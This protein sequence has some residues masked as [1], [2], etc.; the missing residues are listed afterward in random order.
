[1][2]TAGQQRLR[3]PVA[4]CPLVDSG[5]EAQIG[6][7]GGCELVPGLIGAQLAPY[8]DRG[9]HRA[10]HRF[11][12][13]G[14]TEISR[15]LPRFEHQHRDDPGEFGR[16]ESLPQPL[17]Q[18]FGDHQIRLGV[19]T[20]EPATVGGH[21]PVADISAFGQQCHDPIEGPRKRIGRGSDL[22][23]HRLVLPLEPAVPLAHP[24]QLFAIGPG[25]RRMRTQCAAQRRQLPIV[26]RPGAPT[27]PAA[28]GSRDSG[29]AQCRRQIAPGPRGAMIDVTRQSHPAQWL[30]RRRKV[31]G[32]YTSGP[33]VCG[34][35]Q[36]ARIPRTRIRFQDHG[37][38]LAPA[39][40]N[41]HHV[42]AP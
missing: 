24:G 1:M 6:F 29:T 33:G 23:A 34:Q 5:H 20:G 40:R 13:P 30:G 36:W 37:Q 38:A 12:R 26:G 9:A 32:R 41:R 8:T 14:R 4:A 42:P 39:G 10:T 11:R 28:A 19:D 35:Y 7:P 21:L 18:A 17:P 31:G 25:V 16:T 3:Q 22:L 2:I 15:L 27:A